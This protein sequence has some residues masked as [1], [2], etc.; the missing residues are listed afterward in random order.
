MSDELS[1]FELNRSFY[2]VVL[3]LLRHLNVHACLFHFRF[4]YPHHNILTSLT[5]ARIFFMQ[6]EWVFGQ[7]EGGG[8]KDRLP[9]AISCSISEM[10]S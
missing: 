6:V 8:V 3:L 5:E 10:V 1:A 7:A 4:R 2:V 9:F